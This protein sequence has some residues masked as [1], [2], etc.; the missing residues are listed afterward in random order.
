MHLLLK[1]RSLVLALVAALVPLAPASAAL[2]EVEGSGAIPG[3]HSS[4]QLRRYLTLQTAEAEP[5]DWRFGPAAAGDAPAPDRVKW[6]FKLHP[7]AGGE[8]RTFVLPY[9]EDKTFGVHRPITIEARLF[10]NGEY[11]T[12]VK[13]KSIIEG[14]PDDPDLAPAVA[15]LTQNLL[16]PSGA[17]G[18]LN[19]GQRQG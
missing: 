16:R 4:G 8:V 2:L 10:L 12:L 7:Y 18:A 9:M 5:A 17:Y 14:G 15:S 13:G 3:F 11:Q 1:W 6:R 19:K